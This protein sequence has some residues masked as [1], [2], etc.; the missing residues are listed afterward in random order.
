MSIGNNLKRLREKNGFSQELIAEKIGVSRQAVSKWENDTSNPSNSQ[1]NTNT[2]LL[3][4]RLCIRKTGCLR[5]IH[6]R[7]NSWSS[8]NST[9]PKRRPTGPYWIIL[10]RRF[11]SD[12]PQRRRGWTEKTC[13]AFL[14]TGLRRRFVCWKQSKEGCCV[15]FIISGLRIWKRWTCA[16]CGGAGAVM[17]GRSCRISTVCR[18]TSPDGAPLWWRIPYDVMCRIWGCHRSG[19]LCFRGACGVYGGRI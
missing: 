5:P 9:M 15:R 16:G 10:C 11:F 4:C 19:L 7:M 17:T 2:S 13:C 6:R 3:R 18:D 1:N 14:M 12:W 8:T